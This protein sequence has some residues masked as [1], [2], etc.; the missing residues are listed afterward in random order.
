[1]ILNYL[2]EL[3]NRILLIFGMWLCLMVITYSNKETLLFLFSKPWLTI[4]ILDHSVY[5]I[6][7]NFTEIL[8]SY[9][10]ISYFLSNQITFIYFLYHFIV[11]LGP[12]F[13]CKE[14][15]LSL[16]TYFIFLILF[17]S[18]FLVFNKTIVPFV[19]TFFLTLQNIL[20]S[21]VF[22]LY[23]EAKITEYLNFYFILY[24][25]CL[26]SF[27]SITILLMVSEI[28]I[29][30]NFVLFIKK[31]RKYYYL[32][33]ITISIAISPPEINLQLGIIFY[34]LV[35]YEIFLVCIIFK[36]NLQ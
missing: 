13:Y 36:K 21:Q 1:M 10:K 27:S 16:T 12:G 31:Y 17:L 18:F 22:T 28:F 7:T 3:K 34:F 2:I 14:Y 19:C 5:F 35:F 4:S 25:L 15:R 24:K 8:I 32:L 33:L 26:I 20:T 29:Y 30:S 9:V 6:S 11:F 23:F